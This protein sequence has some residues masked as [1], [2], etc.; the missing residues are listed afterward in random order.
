VALPDGD[1]LAWLEV[2][3]QLHCVKYLRQWIYRDHYHPDVDDDDVPHLLLH[4]DHCLEL[5]R[6]AVMCR[7]DS[8]LMT[9]EWKDGEDKPML[10]LESPEHVCADW[11]DL[12]GKMQSRVVDEEEMDRLSNPQKNISGVDGS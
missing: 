8:T 11:D 3:H 2:Y 1:Y 12:V 9:F 10:K 5:L 7:A 6:Q 4:T